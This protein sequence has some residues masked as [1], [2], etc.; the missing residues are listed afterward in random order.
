MTSVG[1]NR[2][3]HRQHTRHGF[4]LTPEL[5]ELTASVKFHEKFTEPAYFKYQ[6]RM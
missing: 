3:L 1:F 5:G 4:T 6:L 2:Q